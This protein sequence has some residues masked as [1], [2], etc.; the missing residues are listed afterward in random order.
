MIASPCLI[1]FDTSVTPGGD[2]QRCS[3]VLTAERPEKNSTCV[4]VRDE[5]VALRKQVQGVLEVLH[6]LERLQR[7]TS[8]EL[9]VILDR[10]NATARILSTFKRISNVLV[11]IAHLA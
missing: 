1:C 11:H 6:G 4:E 7:A 5:A 8:N 2:Q 9:N 10:V 3:R